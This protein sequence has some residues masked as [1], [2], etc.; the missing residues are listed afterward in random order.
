MNVLRTMNSLRMSFWMVPAS[1]ACFAPCV[2]AGED[3]EA[4]ADGR[5]EV[6]DAAWSVA[7]R[8]THLLLRGDDV[9]GQDGQHGAVHR[10][11]HRHLVQRD[12]VKENLASLRTGA[13]RG[14]RERRS[15]RGPAI[16]QRRRCVPSCPR[17]SRWRRRPCPRRPA[18]AGGPSRSCAAEGANEPFGGKDVSGPARP[19]GRALHPNGT[20]PRWV[21]RSKATERPCW[22]AA[23]FLR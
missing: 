8:R 18:R 3:R 1:S 13:G 12:A 17:P 20:D 5:S 9:H 6:A 14:G 16:G 23:R 10:H 4:G 7:G 19:S 22:P 11:R 2:A 15:P 21:A